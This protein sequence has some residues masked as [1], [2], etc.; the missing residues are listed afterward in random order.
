MRATAL[1]DCNCSL[2]VLFVGR[3]EPRERALEWR[4]AGGRG[5]ARSVSLCGIALRA[6]IYA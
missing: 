3:L 4:G 5:A 1:I 6:V 2:Q